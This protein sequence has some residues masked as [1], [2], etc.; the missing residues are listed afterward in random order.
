MKFIRRGL[1]VL[2][3]GL[4]SFPMAGSA[5]PQDTPT[6][7]TVAAIADPDWKRYP[8]FSAGVA[9]FE[10]ERRTAPGAPLRFRLFTRD[11]A[12]PPG[13]LLLRIATDTE[14]APVGVGPD[15]RFALPH[16]AWALEG[17]A[18][19]LSNQRRGS[20]R[21]RPDIRSPAVPAGF[22]RL[23]DLRLECRV[24]WTIE[25]ADVPGLMRKVF[26]AAGG[27]CLARDVLVDFF[28]D[29][30]IGRIVVETPAGDRPLPCA[31][32]AP[33]GR[34]YYPPIND[35]SLGDDVLLRF[36]AGGDCAPPTAAH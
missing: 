27:P 11:G 31:R 4:C 28:S 24:R 21:W 36:E 18:E 34:K 30:P 20:T 16:L 35:Q 12:L 22:R 25:R 13:E 10:A 17:K 5:Q 8:A 14:S 19:I 1:L 3:A 2:A 9:F 7:V 26:D 23:G 29:E 15:G 6:V 32:A 33:G